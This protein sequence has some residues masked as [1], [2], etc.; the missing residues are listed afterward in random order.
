MYRILTVFLFLLPFLTK[1]QTHTSVDQGA[2]LYKYKNGLK[3]DSALFL[4][5]KDT[6]TADLTMRA[7]GMLV[8]RPQDSL[9]Y[10]RKGDAMTPVSTGGGDL[11]N[12]YTKSQSDT[13]FVHYTDTSLMLVPYLRKSDTSS[14]LS[15][16]LRKTDTA[17]MLNNYYTKTELQTA[18]QA[19]V[20]WGNLTNITDAEAN[21]EVKGIAT[22]NGNDFNDDGSGA[23]SIDYPNGPDTRYPLLSGSYVNP[24]WVSSL[25]WSKITGTPT[26]LSGYGITDAVINTRSVNT[27]SP[28]QGGGNLTADRTLSILDAAADGATKGAASFT[29][30]D[31]NSSTGN[32]SIDYTNGPP[33]SG[34]SGLYRSGTNLRLGTNQ[35]LEN[36]NIPLNSFYFSLTGN[37]LP[38]GTGATPTYDFRHENNQAG[39][40]GMYTK[41][42][43]KSGA[44]VMSFVGDSVGVAGG[45]GLYGRTFVPANDNSYSLPGYLQVNSGS[46]AS[47]VNLRAINPNGKVRIGIDSMTMMVLDS[48]RI[49]SG[50]GVKAIQLWP[51]NWPEEPLEIVNNGNTIIPDSP[52][53]LIPTGLIKNNWALLL[54]HGIKLNNTTHKWESWSLFRPT[55]AVEAGYEGATLHAA[56]WGK[57]FSDQL[58]EALQARGK[59]IDGANGSAQLDTGKWVQAKVPIIMKFTTTPYEGL[60][61]NAPWEGGDQ[62]PFVW[63]LSEE[64]K[65]PDGEYLRIEQNA[66]T[67]SG[68]QFYFRKSRG[69]NGSKVAGSSGD[70]AGIINWSNYDGANYV[71]GARI[72]SILEAT[73]TAGNSPTSLRFDA[74]TNGPVERMRLTSGGNLGIGLTPTSKLHVNGSEA[75][76]VTAI[77]SNTTLGE[78]NIVEI[79][80]GSITITLPT[81]STCSGRVYEIRNRTASTCTITSVDIDG[82]GTTTFPANTYWKILSNGSA[83]RLIARSN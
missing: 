62:R 6:V 16:Y 63:L 53:H 65:S 75:H 2:T 33:A 27:T 52:L 56:T 44:A 1:G 73:A 71:T 54:T 60:G 61:D 9:L 17:G 57:N 81:A 4:P 69:T 15:P 67:T 46:Q 29:A 58:H 47:G 50:T 72:M 20:H 68:G 49:V 3:V 42:T 10:Y 51:K 82:V 55:S 31:F 39:I 66:A 83:W 79:T 11:S 24:S 36:A 48:S 7:P 41:N 32:I 40:S 30:A 26:T 13:R 19:A 45:I 59:G 12:Y 23:I 64:T 37:G 38:V 21:G 18:G 5:R 74:G 43:D 70:M 77:S 80:T 28:L 78:H 8:Y 35:L 34:E 22:F 25:A 14:M 76:L